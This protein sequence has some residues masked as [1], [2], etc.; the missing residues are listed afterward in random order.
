M[1]QFVG[2]MVALVVAT[3]I[4]I[5]LPMRHGN[6][7]GWASA[8]STTDSTTQTEQPSPT[9]GVALLSVGV[10]ARTSVAGHIHD[11][12]APASLDP[13][14]GY[15]RSIS[16]PA[17]RLRLASSPPLRTFPLLI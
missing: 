17:A 2:R 3:V 9:P 8:S 15:G 11:V 14:R 7:A 5:W 10:P 16:P 13:F 1:M 4:A 6:V 12:L